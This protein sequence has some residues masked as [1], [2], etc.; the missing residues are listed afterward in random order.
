MRGEINVDERLKALEKELDSLIN[1]APIED[2]FM[3]MKCIRIWQTRKQ[4]NNG[5]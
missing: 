2:D 4:Y 5:S 3:K 1:M